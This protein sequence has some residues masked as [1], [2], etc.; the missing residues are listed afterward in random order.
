MIDFEPLEVG[1]LDLELFDGSRIFGFVVSLGVD[2]DERIP[3][4]SRRYRQHEVDGHDRCYVGAGIGRMGNLKL[5]RNT[6]RHLTVQ[7][8]LLTDIPHVGRPFGGQEDVV[9]DI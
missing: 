9:F 5:V 8:I 6:L 3:V 7:W 2:G 4:L 1:S